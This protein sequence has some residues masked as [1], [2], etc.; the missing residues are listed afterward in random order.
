MRSYSLV[1]AYQ[2]GGAGLT[3]HR[4]VLSIGVHPTSHLHGAPCSAHHGLGI[5]SDDRSVRLCLWFYWTGKK[6][7]AQRV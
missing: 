2:Q 4:S 5:S 6:T 1:V 3:E 7:E